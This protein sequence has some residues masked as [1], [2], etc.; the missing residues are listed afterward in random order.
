MK[1]EQL[2]DDEDGDPVT[3]LVAYHLSS[4]D[5]IMRAQQGEQAAGRG[6][7][8]QIFMTLV[9]NGMEEKTLRKAFYEELGVTDADVRKKAY[10][11]A[12]DAAVRQKLIEVVEGVIIDLRKGR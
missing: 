5:E 12:R 9:Q 7:R 4:E 8:Q 11:R 10:Y 6:G 1:V 2:R 3:S